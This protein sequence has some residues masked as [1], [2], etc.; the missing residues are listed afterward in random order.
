MFASVIIT[1]AASFCVETPEPD[2]EV[3]RMSS[4]AAP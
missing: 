3:R 4:E 2:T 1:G